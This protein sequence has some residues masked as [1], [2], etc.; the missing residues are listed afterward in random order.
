MIKANYKEGTSDY[1]RR[2]IPDNFGRW[3]GGTT[4]PDNRNYDPAVL[5]RSFTPAG[6]SSSVAMRPAN[7]FQTRLWKGNHESG[8][9]GNWAP[10]MTYADFC[11]LAA[12]FVLRE[13]LS[14]SKT[15]QQWYETGV[16]AS[17][18]QWNAIGKYCGINNYQAMTEDEIEVFLNKPNIQWTSTRSMQLE[19][20]D[21]KIS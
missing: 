6:A 9:G 18:D 2:Y 10:V 15:A 12:E 3:Q 8:T 7:Y 1:I 13:N 5:T 16:R 19:Q 14:S 4:N 21:H 11:F 20:I 17:V